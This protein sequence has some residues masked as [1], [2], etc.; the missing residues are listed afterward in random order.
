M[1]ITESAAGGSEVLVLVL[2]A[3]GSWTTPDEAFS[4]ASVLT[5]IKREV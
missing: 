1:V 5:S 2:P 3:G 4:L